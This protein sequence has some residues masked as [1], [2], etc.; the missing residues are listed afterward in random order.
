MKSQHH[1]TL[2]PSESMALPICSMLL[3]A[4]TLSRRLYRR[5]RKLHRKRGLPMRKRH[6]HSWFSHAPQELDDDNI[7]VLERYTNLLYD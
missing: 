1:V 5:V 2:D 4:V 3:Q 6:R 7:A